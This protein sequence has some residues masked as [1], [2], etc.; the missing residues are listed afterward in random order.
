MAYDNKLNVLVNKQAVG[1][2]GKEQQQ[3]YFRYLPTTD[4]DQYVSLTMPVRAR[5]FEHSRLPPI[6]EMHLP[7]GYLLD[8]LKRHF[9]KL[10]GSS[11]LSLLQLIGP[12]MRGRLGYQ[13]TGNSQQNQ[14]LTLDNLINPSAGLFEELVERFALQSPISGVQ[15]KILA[16][17][18]N[19]ASLQL[20]DF[21]V[22]AWGPEYPELA[23]NEYCCMRVLQHAGIPVPEFY[24]SSDRKLF[25]MKRFD[26]KARGECLG[27]EDFCV[28]QAKS[29]D[30][31][32]E[33]SYE[34][35]CKSLALFVSAKYRQTAFEQLFQMLVLNQHL[36]NGDAHLK[37]FAVLY[38]SIQDIWLAPAYDVISTTAY[39]KQDQA[40]LTLM[41]SRKWWSRKHMIN[42]AIQHCQLTKQRAE[43]LYDNC[44]HALTKGAAE[45]KQMLQ[46]AQQLE[47]K[48][49]L[50]HLLELMQV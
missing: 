46:Q 41:G 45:V 34:Q 18:E 10:I 38:Q 39:I 12:N 26:L 37:N 44:E 40:A 31:K 19:K 35:L 5:S 30:D 20:E 27:F 43:E 17:V 13:Q 15:P 6:F 49:V 9:S 16:Q 1:E 42:F 14:P 21:I 3:Y 11:D 28:L 8:V 32:Y 50:E 33:G 36:Q 47:Q 4:A 48:M 23:L 25:I 2:L 7:E 29:R 22:K 24:L